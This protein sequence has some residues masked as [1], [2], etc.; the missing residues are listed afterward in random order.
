VAATPNPFCHIVTWDNQ[1]VAW[2]DRENIFQGWQLAVSETTVNPLP[3]GFRPEH[4]SPELDLLSAASYS[5]LFS[6]PADPDA[7]LNFFASRH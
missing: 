6:P 2:F 1:V 5:Y 3:A 4:N 7:A